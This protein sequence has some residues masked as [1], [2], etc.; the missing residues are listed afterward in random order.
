MR[1]FIPKRYGFHMMQ[2]RVFP[3]S[4]Y[5]DIE[6]GVAKVYAVI[7]NRRDPDWVRMHISQRHAARRR[8]YG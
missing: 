2:S 8:G 3:Y 5:Y 7:D 4:V 6:G 1:G